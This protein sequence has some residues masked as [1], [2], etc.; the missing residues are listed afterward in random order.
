MPHFIEQSVFSVQYCFLQQA[1]DLGLF[2]IVTQQNFELG[3][4][5]VTAAVLTESHAF[6]V[7]RG[8]V[9]GTEICACTDMQA[10]FPDAPISTLQQD[11]PP[12]QEHVLADVRYNFSHKVLSV[13]QF[14]DIDATICA[15]TDART[16]SFAFPEAP[17]ELPAALTKL[18]LIPTTSRLTTVSIHTYPNEQLL[19]YTESVWH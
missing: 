18:Y 6:L 14:A 3:D 12:A 1:A 16:L 9:V 13:D 5:S 17:D 19:L 8:D 11:T 10:L 4:F 2:N 7:K 15:R